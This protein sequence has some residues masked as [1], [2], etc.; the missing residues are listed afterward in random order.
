MTTERL[1][2]VVSWLLCLGVL[3]FGIPAGKR[4]EA[5]IVFFFSQIITWTL[6]LV[7]VQLG[8]ISNPV[9]EFEKATRANFT[10][11]FLLYPTVSMMFSMYYPSKSSKLKQFLY[12]LAIIGVV[13]LS[14][15]YVEV[16]TE[17]MEFN[18]FNWF[19][20]GLVLLFGVNAS[21]KYAQ[22]YFNHLPDK[23]GSK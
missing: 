3:A 16:Y 23:G 19:I 4:R 14:M 7:F 22:W 11:N 13:S 17:L 21:R 18:H 12:Q 2:L 8:M 1:I 5:M 10:F 15:Q 6:S 9:R 20:G